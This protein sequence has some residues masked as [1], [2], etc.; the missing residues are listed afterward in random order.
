MKETFAYIGGSILAITLLF[1]FFDGLTVHDVYVLEDATV[2]R[3]GP[4][5][6]GFIGTEEQTEIKFDSG[7]VIT[8]GGYKGKPGDRI[9]HPR[10]IGTRSASGIFKSD[11]P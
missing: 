4:D 10:V 1:L 3:T 7:L 2:I 9:K 11:R 6:S 8:V 5:T